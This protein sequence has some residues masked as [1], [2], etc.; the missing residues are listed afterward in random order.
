M[1]TTLHPNDFH[2]PVITLDFQNPDRCTTGSFNLNKANSHPNSLVHGHF[3]VPY[4]ILQ[5]RL[6]KSSINFLAEKPGTF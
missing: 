4:V 3:C 1:N 2:K 5:G 6:V